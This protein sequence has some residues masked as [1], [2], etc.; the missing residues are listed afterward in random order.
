[1]KIA[2]LG[3]GKMGKLIKQVAIHRNHKIILQTNSTPNQNEIKNANI[4]IEFTNS[5]SVIENLLLC[6]KNNIPIICGTTG[7]MDQLSYIKKKCKKYQG[8][9]LFSPNFSIGVNIFF[10]INQILSSIM[11]KYPEYEIKIQE[12]HHIEKKDIPS[13]TSIKIATDI[14]KNNNTK[15]KWTTNIKNFKKN[16]IPIE[17][18]RIHN[19][20]GIHS[21]TYESVID[22]LEI[23]HIANNREGFALGAVLAAEWLFK[24]KKKGFFSM[25]NVLKI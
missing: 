14:I 10:K 7:W 23:N 22:K 3:Y 1:M 20:P 4:A 5:K 18:K 8:S 6:L 13:G 11:N 9:I 12:I 24:S 2:I 15:N 19:V 21:I 25:K 17:S 16:E